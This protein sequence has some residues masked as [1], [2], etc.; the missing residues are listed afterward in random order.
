MVRISYKEVD[1]NKNQEELVK[2]MQIIV[3][4]D[5]TLNQRLIEQRLKKW[6]YNV[7]VTDKAIYGLN[8][9]KNNKIDLVLMDLKMPEMDGYEITK[10]LDAI[11][12]LA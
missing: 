11:K 5:N 7:F 2:N 10:K 8:I 9:L 12:I 6:K 1:K 3:F 4:E